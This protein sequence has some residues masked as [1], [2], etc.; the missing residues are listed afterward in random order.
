MRGAPH[1]GFSLQ[2]VRCTPEGDVE[3]VT[4]EEVLD[5]QLPPRFEQI[6]DQ[7]PKQMEDGK[8][9]MFPDSPSDANP[10]DGFFGTAGTCFK[11][12]A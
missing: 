7:H 5:F 4:K 3:L 12:I 10:R 1:K 2:T 9:R 8:H 11:A 6:G